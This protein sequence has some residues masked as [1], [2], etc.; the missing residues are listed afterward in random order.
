MPRRSVVAFAI[1]M[2]LTVRAIAQARKPPASPGTNTQTGQGAPD[3]KT[4][5]P[6]DKSKPDDK[7]KTSPTSSEP[8][9][10]KITL[11]F[12]RTPIALDTEAGLSAE[13]KNV[14]T[15]PVT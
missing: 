6:D 9:Y 1:V 3:A 8:S 4:S 5:R 11:D 10:L 15:V 12:S 7:T 13:L 14:S 2:M